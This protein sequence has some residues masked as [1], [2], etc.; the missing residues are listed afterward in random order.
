MNSFNYS[1]KKILINLLIVIGLGALLVFLFLKVYLPLYTNHGETVSVPDLSGYGYADASKLLENTGLQY[2]ISLDSG[3]STELPAL[4]ILKQMPAANSQVKTGRKIYLTLNARNA[5][6]IKMPNLVN[7]LLKNAQEMLSNMGLERGDI[8]YVPDIGFNVV[9]EQRYR[10]VQVKEGFEIPKG[11][12][13]DVVVGDGNGNQLLFVP[14]LTGMD[15]EE[16]EFLI[17]GSGLKLGNKNYSSSDSVAPGQIFLQ[18]PP[19][20]SQVRVGDTIDIWISK[21]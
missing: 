3:F 7:M 15:A 4:A 14:D 1:I 9:L 5:P 17:L 2:E 11:A 19:A 10:G 6:L 13:I 12:R 16:G 21:N 8:I 20:G 18:A